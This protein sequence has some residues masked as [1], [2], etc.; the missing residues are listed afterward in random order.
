MKL[1]NNL[2]IGIRLGLAFAMCVAVML[3]LTATAKF[4]LTHVRDDVELINKDRYVKVRLATDVKDD[5]SVV[6]LSAHNLVIAKT[7]AERE[8]DM[9]EIGAA[10]ARIGE[11]FKKIDAMLVTEAAKQ[12]LSKVLAA[13]QNFL[14]EVDVLQQL[15]RADDAAKL[16][17]QLEKLR[18]VQREYVKV[19]G[20]YA[21]AQEEQMLKAGEDTNLTVDRTSTM[22]IVAA[23][24]GASVAVAAAWGTTLSITR[25]INRAVQVARTVAAGDLTSRIDVTRNDE[26]GQLLEALKLMNSS[27]IGIVNQVRQ[28]SDNIATGSGQIAIGNQDLSQR[29]EEQASN[30]QQTAASMEQLTSTVKNNADAARQAS[31]FASAA[32]EVAAKG[33]AVV[34]QVVGTMEQITSAS[35]KIADIIGVIDG[36]AFQTNILAL[37][38]AV[39]A[40]RAGEQ[41]RGFAVVAGEVR[42]L[43]QRSAQA[44]KEIKLLIND[45]V[46]TVQAGSKLVLDAGNT[47]DD[48][49]SQV[50]R[51][52][53]LISEISAATLQQSSGISQV[54]DAVVQLDQVTQ[55]NA[56][57][58]EESAAAAESLK[59]QAQQLVQAVASFRLDPSTV[60]TPAAHASPPPVSSKPPA[61]RPVAK[62]TVV[63]IKREPAQPVVDAPVAARESWVSF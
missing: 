8:G 58:V 30:L 54:G 18:P 31:Q 20:D 36:I 29:T 44:A 15:A 59:H 5:V 35:K 57:L 9:K 16:H 34:G 21:D 38:A 23:L 56:A 41:G 28:S 12:D 48:I 1:F 63:S 40:A 45:S 61:T 47:M 22:L 14:R 32:S 27:L 24:I 60:A 37:N 6:V 10:R 26:T 3:A 11:T 46:E 51:V 4:G 53:D 50:T 2:K 49:V 33:G 7:P 43:A 39:E 55:Q 42:S 62:P 25:P 52:T 17:A 13:R 19:L